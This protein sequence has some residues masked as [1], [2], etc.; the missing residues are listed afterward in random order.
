MTTEDADAKVT[1]SITLP[2]SVWDQLREK[3]DMNDRTLNGE[4]A[5]RLKRSLDLDE[6]ANG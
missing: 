1:R 5:F 4:I 3:A 2:R 6:T